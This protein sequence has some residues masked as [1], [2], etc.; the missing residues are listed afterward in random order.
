MW[1]VIKLTLIVRS[2][3][4]VD[5]LMEKNNNDGGCQGVQFLI[6][7]SILSKLYTQYQLKELC[8]PQLNSSLGKG[9][10]TK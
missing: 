1:S 5:V 8:L 4:N 3:E 6:P 7:W 2:L 9:G 10:A